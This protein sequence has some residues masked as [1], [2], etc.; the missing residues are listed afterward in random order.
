MLTSPLKSRQEVMD[1]VKNLNAFAKARE[2][3]LRT[4]Y[5]EIGIL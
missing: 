1:R 3:A 5:K 4:L 2:A